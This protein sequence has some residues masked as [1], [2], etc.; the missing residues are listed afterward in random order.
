MTKAEREHLAR[1]AETLVLAVRRYVGYHRSP[2]GGDGYAYAVGGVT[3]HLQNFA[4]D[5]ARGKLPYM[6][7]LVIGPLYE[8]SPLPPCMGCLCAG[9][10]RGNGYRVPCDT[11]EQPDDVQP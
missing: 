7:S 10:A 11:S 5:I 3:A 6:P 2:D 4:D 9:H 1:W 8:P